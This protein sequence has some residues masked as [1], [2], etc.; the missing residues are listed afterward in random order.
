MTSPVDFISG[1]GVGSN[2]RS[3]M[4][5]NTG[6]LTATA[7]SCLSGISR[8]DSLSPIVSRAAILASGMPVDFATNGK[9]LDPR[10]FTSRTYRRSPLIAYWMLKQPITPSSSPII[11]VHSSTMERILSGTFWVG[12]KQHV[13]S[14]E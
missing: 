3:L 10:G 8:S 9:V 12:M 7:S 5:G 13:E 1:P 11:R 2:P 14:P 4:K 6:A